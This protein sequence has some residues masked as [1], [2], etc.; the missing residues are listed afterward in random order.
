MS[1]RCPLALVYEYSLREWRACQTA[2]EIRRAA[3]PRRR[4]ATNIG[5]V[6]LLRELSVDEAAAVESVHPGVTIRL[7]DLLSA[8]DDVRAQLSEWGIT[9]NPISTVR[10][11]PPTP[12]ADWPT[13]HREGVEAARDGA[14][15]TA[16]SY[17]LG[18]PAGGGWYCGWASVA[19]AP[20]TKNAEDPD[21]Q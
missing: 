19:E 16:N 11:Q 13:A 3:S 18:T 2:T 9:L 14:A 21:V 7:L 10:P 1:R 12:R 17:E 4:D 15:S 5:A 6:I 20:P 8:S